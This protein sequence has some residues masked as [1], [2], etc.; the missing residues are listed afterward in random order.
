MRNFNHNKLLKKIQFKNNK[1]QATYM[2]SLF[3]IK[4]NK[5]NNSLRRL[6]KFKNKLIV[7]SYK[8]RN[9]L[10]YMKFNN[11]MSKESSIR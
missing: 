6:R 1:P 8:S 3:Q 7:K 4:F 10:D 2:I 9:S 11:E 5:E